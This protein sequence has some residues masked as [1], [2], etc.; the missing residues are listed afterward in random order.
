MSKKDLRR[1]VK[2]DYNLLIL[3]GMVTTANFVPDDNFNDS[4]G[5]RHFPE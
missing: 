2:P 5:F 4:F 3:L 1:R